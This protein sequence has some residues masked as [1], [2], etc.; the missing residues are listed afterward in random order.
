MRYGS[1]PL[2]LREGV[3]FALSDTLGCPG[4]RLLV[5]VRALFLQPCPPAFCYP[6]PGTW[7]L[8]LGWSLWSHQAVGLDMISQLAWVSCSFDARDV[9]TRAK[10]PGPAAGC[11][12]SSEELW[13]GLPSAEAVVFL[14]LCSLTLRRNWWVDLSGTWWSN[15][16]TNTIQTT[17]TYKPLALK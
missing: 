15:M 12:S 8:P 13:T 10:R 16:P 4:Y 14:H 3:L 6:S 2:V 11:C 17:L 5:C 7:P 9:P 1:K